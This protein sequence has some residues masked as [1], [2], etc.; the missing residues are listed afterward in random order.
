MI[1]GIDPKIDYAFKRLF[2]LDRNRDILIDLLHAVLEPA[3]PIAD[4]EILN[5]FNPKETEEDKLSIV[6]IK[7][8]DQRGRLFNVE[9]QMV[10]YPALPK[11]LLYY[12]SRVYHQQLHEGEDYESLQ[13]TI[14]ICFLDDVLFPAVADHHLQFRLMDAH[15]GTVLTDDIQVH[16]LELRKFRRAERDL[17]SPLDRWLFFLRHAELLDAEALPAVLTGPAIQRA[18]KELRM[19]TQNDRERELYEAREKQRRDEVSRLN[20][21]KRAGYKDGLVERV[22]M[23][24][25]ILQQNPSPDAELQKLSVDDLKA[26]AARLEQELASKQ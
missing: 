23:C 11:R 20:A 21:A 12:W 7:V 19:I 17:A 18:V 1:L 9:M 14:S 13:P 26:L 15:H 5:P 6:D 8:R 16:L 24:Q 2:G 3:D 22:Q 25:R 4:V 10:V